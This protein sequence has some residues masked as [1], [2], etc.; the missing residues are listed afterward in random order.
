LLQTADDN[1]RYGFALYVC[2][3]DT[4]KQQI[5]QVNSNAGVGHAVISVNETLHEQAHRIN[6]PD[7]DHA[8]AIS[9]SYLPTPPKLIA[10]QFS[11]LQM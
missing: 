3:L 11:V 1:F 8:T 6:S 9:P 7:D 4:R 10:G 5:K 2:V